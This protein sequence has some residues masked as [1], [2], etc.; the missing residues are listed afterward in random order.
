MGT[1]RNRDWG[2]PLQ[3]SR[4]M[5][6]QRCCQKPIMAERLRKHRMSVF[7]GVRF[8]VPSAVEHDRQVH[9]AADLGYP[10]ELRKSGLHLRE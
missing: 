2:G 10:L 1:D 9:L 7:F 3:L 5:N 8:L 4:R 6:V